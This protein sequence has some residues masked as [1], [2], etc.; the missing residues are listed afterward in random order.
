MRSAAIVAIAAS[1]MNALTGVGLVMYFS[2]E[3][4]ALVN[5]R[6]GQAAVASSVLVGVANVVVSMAAVPLIARIN[7]RPLLIIGLGG[8]ATSL[9]AVA[10][11]LQLT[12]LGIATALAVIGTIAFMGFFAISAGPL[13]WVILSEVAPAQYRN[14]VTSSAVAANWSINLA[15]TMLFP[16]IVGSPPDHRNVALCYVGFMLVSLGFA[17]F[18]W[19]CVPETRGLT[20]DEIQLRFLDRQVAREI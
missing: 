4:F 15:L 11:S 1:L 7:R 5:G 19:R 8:M 3:I 9:L 2:T 18:V 20:L 17:A 6:G 12:R 10:A 16:I 14:V 13:A